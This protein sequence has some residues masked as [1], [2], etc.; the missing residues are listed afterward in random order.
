MLLR[1]LFLV[2]PL[3]CSGFLPAALGDDPPAET[4]AGGQAAPAEAEHERVYI[5]VDRRTEAKGYVE[6]E[7]DEV[8]VIRWKDEVQSFAKG[9]VFR[10]VR[11]VDPAPGQQGYVVLRDGQV[12]RGTIIEDSFDEV[13][14]EIEG[15]RSVFPRELV[16]HV[17][18]QPTFEQRLEQM[19]KGLTEDNHLARFELA[20][21]LFD[22]RQ[23]AM[24]R[25]ELTF[26]LDR[27]EM[28][29]AR[30]LMRLVDA[31]LTLERAG[32]HGTGNEG[33]AGSDGLGGAPGGSRSGRVDQRDLVPH[34]LLT[35]D[36][37]NLIRVYEMDF[38]RPP[39]VTVSPDTIRTL[40]ERYGASDLIPASS[41][42]RTAM[43]RAEPLDIV[44]LMFRLK[45]RELYPDVKV[46]TEP[47]HLNLFR[48][49]VHNAWLMNNCATSRCHGGVDAGGLFLHNRNY[50][51]E[52]VRY[53]NLLI[54]DS[55]SF[56]GR[57][58]V[59]YD[60]PLMSLLIQYGLPRTEAR[61]PHPDVKGWRPAF[62]QANQRLLSDAVNW[63]RGM[64]QPRPHYPVDYEPPD[65]SV[66]DR[67]DAPADRQDR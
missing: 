51:D 1:P 49:R 58:L 12:R 36:D 38:R 64:Y 65:L 28:P 62:T 55:L 67:A 42:E 52:R 45:A 8:I 46:L 27:T 2:L 53:T 10:I 5:F 30:Q 19:R 22:Q 17:E 4:P 48:Q 25:E 44:R 24:C 35:A 14:L 26:I 31:Q 60:D 29:E 15:I 43:F 63:I 41:E 34:R 37:V 50:K 39:R 20:R 3:V 56:N 18:L 7:D 32:S 16:D 47:E 61:L 33:S 66:P 59:D 40:I 21:W 9:R 13:T 54:L 23:Y 6:T 11:L 57:R